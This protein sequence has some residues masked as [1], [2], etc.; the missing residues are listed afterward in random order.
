MPF[1]FK[2]QLSIFFVILELFGRVIEDHVSI[3]LP[4]LLNKNLKKFHLGDLLY[5]SLNHEYIG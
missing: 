5:S 4:S 1:F 3:S 2:L